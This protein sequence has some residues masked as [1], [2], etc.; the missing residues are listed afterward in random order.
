M[1]AL[2]GHGFV[3]WPVGNGDSTT[4]GVDSETYIQIDVRDLETARDDDDPHVAVIDRLVELLPTNGDGK[5]YLAAFGLTHADEDHCLGF[6]E[7]LERVHIG[8]LWFSPYVLL[9]EDDLSEDAEVFCEE[10]RRRVQLNIE[11]GDVGSGDRIRVIGH[12]D[13]LG[14]APYVGLPGDCLVVPGTA[15]GVIDG[16]D[17]G[18]KVRVFAHGPVGSDD[19]V[20]RNDSSMAI[21][22]TL[23]RDEFSARLLMFGDLAYP[24]V[25]RI[26]DDGEDE[27]LTWDVLLAPHHCSKSVFYYAADDQAEPTLQQDLVDAMSEAATEAARVVASCEPIPASNEPGD[28]PPHAD[29]LKRYEEMVEEVIVTGEHPNEETPEPVVFEF[30]DDGEFAYLEPEGDRGSG[31]QSVAAAV[32]AGRGGDEPPAQPVGFGR[33]R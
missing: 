22:V 2:P 27:D 17:Q 18:D 10:A 33:W 6:E 9:D 32:A 24:G 19:E 31:A 1:E 7:L 4:I 5:P 29:A 16:V 28:D 30:G 14:E 15:F 11:G 13:V 20:E 26:F 3:F 25:K 21:Q 8:E 23:K 12:H